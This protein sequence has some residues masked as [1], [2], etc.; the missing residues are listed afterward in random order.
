[1]YLGP[2]RYHTLTYSGGGIY[3]VTGWQD[4][5]N[6]RPVSGVDDSGWF[7]SPI[8]SDR[9][10]VILLF[11]SH[12]WKLSSTPPRR[13]VCQQWICNAHGAFSR[14]LQSRYLND[15]FLFCSSDIF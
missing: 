10:S 6:L 4:I 12:T 9:D 7:L 11:L 13:T 1:M 2:G 3:D 5:A 15:Y 8:S 14:T